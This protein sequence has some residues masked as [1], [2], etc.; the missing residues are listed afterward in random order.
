MGSDNQY[1]T[2]TT[3]FGSI[4][5]D[6]PVFLLRGRD[7]TLVHV[8]NRHLGLAAEAGAPSDYLG[9]VSTALDALTTWQAANGTA[10]AASVPQA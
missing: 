1:G 10:V 8:M 4:P 7:S 2:V 6:E 3:Q 5:A 9:A